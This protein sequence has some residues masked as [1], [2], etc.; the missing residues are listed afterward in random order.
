MNRRMRL[1]SGQYTSKGVKRINQD[2][3]GAMIPGGQLLDIKGAVF[4][5]ADGIS[6]SDVSQ[7]ASETAVKCFLSDYYCTS[8]AWSVQTSGRKVIESANG[9]L[10]A[11]TQRTDYRFNKEKGYV[12]TF[13]TL[14]LKGATAHL[15]HVGD[16]RIYRLRSDGMETLTNDHRVWVSNDES[17]LSRALGID[18]ALDVDYHTYALAEGDTFLLCTD[19]VYEFVEASDISAALSECPQNLD[20]AAETIVNKAIQNGSN[21]NLTLQ[22]VRIDQLNQSVDRVLK[23]QVDD[24]KLPPY[25]EPREII[26]GYRVVREL[27]ST[28]RS[29]VYLVEDSE[30]NT[31]S[32][33]KIPSIDLRDDTHYLERFLMEEWVARR[34]NNAHVMKAG[35][36]SRKRNYLY[37][38]ME[39]I[40]GQTLAQWIIDNPKPDLETVRKIIEQIASGLQAM[41]RKEILHQDLRPENIM[42]EPSGTVRIIDFGSVRVAGI[43]E[44]NQNIDSPDLPG[45]ALYMAPEYFIGEVISTRSDLFSLAVICYHILSGRFPYDTNVAKSTTKAAQNR[46]NYQSVLDDEREIPA[47]INETLRKA[48]QPNPYKRYPEI[49]EFIFDLRKPNNQYIHKSLPPLIERSPVLFWKSVSM[50]LL[51]TVIGLLSFIHISL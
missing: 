6:S 47:W 15:F 25:L 8:E 48:L 1:S 28:S 36:Q 24:L 49:S 32:V 42:I 29:H 17:Y 46:L 37:T 12:C 3:H 51:L 10:V 27:H 18:L 2:F 21:D 23:Q 16:S 20:K 41:H 39:Y 26:D 50:C 43:E 33:M 45:T 4:A 22:I 9:W 31:Q 30:D 7:I 13:S 14:V 44:T 38:I 35:L 34:I 40:H 19:G 11:Q 5:L